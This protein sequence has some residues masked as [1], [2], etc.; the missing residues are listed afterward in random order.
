[1]KR[2]RRSWIL[3]SASEGLWDSVPVSSRKLRRRDLASRLSSKAR[4]KC[5]ASLD[6]DWLE[7]GRLVM[8]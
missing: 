1:M 4:S 7:E 2:V 5:L 8:P 3:A 6:S